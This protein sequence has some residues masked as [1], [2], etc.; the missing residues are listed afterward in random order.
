MST[1]EETLLA[2]LKEEHEQLH[3]LQS[4]LEVARREYLT[5]ESSNAKWRAVQVALYD[6]ADHLDRHFSFEE[7]DGFLLMVVRRRPTLTAVVE[8]LRREHDDL[9]ER[10]NELNA[11][12]EMVVRTIDRRESAGPRLQALLDDLAKHESKE[13]AVVQGTFTTTELD[14][15]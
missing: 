4:R 3:V 13:H 5:T 2:E 6:L 14:P 11:Q 7:Q 15:A 9:R 10:F 1:T 8:E 12:L